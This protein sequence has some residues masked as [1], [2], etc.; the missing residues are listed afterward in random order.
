MIY[1][2]RKEKEETAK[3]SKEVLPIIL[4][5]DQRKEH[6]RKN[7]NKNQKLLTKIKTECAK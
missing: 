4:K 5:K 3:D 6:N 1:L 7:K 2:Q